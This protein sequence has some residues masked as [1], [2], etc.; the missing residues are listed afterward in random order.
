MAK[1]ALTN[2]FGPLG[3]DGQEVCPKHLPSFAS[4][5]QTFSTGSLPDG[6][7]GPIS[8]ISE[9][10]H[11]PCHITILAQHNQSPKLTG[12]LS[13]KTALQFSGASTMYRQCKFPSHMAQ[14]PVLPDCQATDCRL[15]LPL[16][17]PPQISM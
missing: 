2:L 15:L 7:V 4:H 13:N 10:F 12:R 16:N 14:F 17:K 5:V 11:L 3:C 6:Y 8:N 1:L 9:T